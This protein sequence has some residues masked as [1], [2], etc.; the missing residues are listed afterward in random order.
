MKIP[1]RDSRMDPRNVLS[2][3]HRLPCLLEHP[4]RPPSKPHNKAMHLVPVVLRSLLTYGNPLILRPPSSSR[5]P[6]SPRHRHSSSLAISL[7]LS[8]WRLLNRK[9]LDP[10]SLTRICSAHQRHC[11]AINTLLR[12]RKPSRLT[13]PKTRS[14]QRS[15]ASSSFPRHPSRPLAPRSSMR[16]C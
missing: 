6:T 9:T 7:C 15:R 13:Q 16:G 2:R 8:R 3:L 14:P 10:P 11:Q 1:L 4:H 5:C 12:T